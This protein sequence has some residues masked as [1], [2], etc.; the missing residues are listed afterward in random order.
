[1]RLITNE[2]LQDQKLKMQN[3]AINQW[4]AGTTSYYSWNANSTTIFN[5]VKTEVNA[6]RP[7]IIHMNSDTWTEWHAA[8]AWGYKSTW[9]V[10]I[11]RLNMWW[12]NITLNWTTYKSSSIDQNLDAIF[13]NNNSNHAA[14]WF[15][16]FN[17]KS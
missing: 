14:Q 5:N 4:Y 17:I 15:T 2:L 12:W 13:Y 16:T 9:T 3:N 10:K 6:S 7:I 1:M 11:V 8:V